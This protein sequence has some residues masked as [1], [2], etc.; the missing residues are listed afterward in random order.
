MN[1]AIKT[2]VNRYN[3]R[4]INDYENALKEIIQEITLLGLWRS[5]F[6]E[7][8]AFYGGSALRILYKLDRFS[9]DLDFSL[10]KKNKNF[11]LEKYCKAVELELK[12]FGFAVIIEKKEKSKKSNIDSAFIKADTRQNMIMINVPAFSSQKIH[13]KKLLKIKLEVDV[14]PPKGF[15]VEA[16]Y[17]F[18][19]IPF[20]VNTYIPSDLF[21]GK[22]HAI[23]FRS[24][25]NRVKGR[26]WYDLIWYVSR[27]TPVHL[28]HLEYRI[29][30]TEN[31]QKKIPLTEEKLKEM[32][33]KK[34][35]TIN[36][37]QAKKDVE[38]FIKDTASLS[39]W[40][41]EYFKIICNK[42]KTV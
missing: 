25:K 33:F 2:M 29:K 19:P 15:S 41:K 22:L 7:K 3:C 11:K 13:A 36:F 6:F 23:L 5:K 21:A 38:N 14:D 18:H 24:W 34:I 27:D 37:D 32:L 1:E 35:K 17:L 30:Q 28:K 20:S 42:I 40:S 16:K 10:L 8:A 39:L 9:E 31:S 4:S 12:S 26:D